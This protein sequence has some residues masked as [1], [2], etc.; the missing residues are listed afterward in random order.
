V[1]LAEFVHLRRDGGDA[2]GVA[3]V[4]RAAAGVVM[5]TESDVAE[6]A[7]R[8]VNDAWG[9]VTRAGAGE[10]RYAVRETTLTFRLE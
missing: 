10:R 8:A 1:R 6:A 4:P 5:T 2:D 9:H 3:S 7:Y